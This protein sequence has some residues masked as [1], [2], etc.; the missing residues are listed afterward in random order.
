[1][2]LKNKQPSETLDFDIDCRKRMDSSDTITSVNASF[3][4]PNQAL[5]IE[6]TSFY[7][8][9][10]AKIY[11]SGGTD[12]TTYKITLLVVTM[13]GTT[14]ETEFLLHVKDL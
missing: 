5:V 14:I 9:T 2:I 8:D 7:D 13:N 11:V 3:S 1:M 10:V 12:N 6:R 4:G